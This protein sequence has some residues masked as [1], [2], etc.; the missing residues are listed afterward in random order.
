MQTH[1][2]VIALIEKEGLDYVKVGAFDI[3][4]ILRGNIWAGKKSSRH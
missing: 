4:G 2:D 3:D 1:D